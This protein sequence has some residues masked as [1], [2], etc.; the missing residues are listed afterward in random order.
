MSYLCGVIKINLIMSQT[1]A[2]VLRK[3]LAKPEEASRYYAVGRSGRVVTIKE[4]AKRIAER[5]SYSRGELEGCVGEYLL[6]IL[7]VLEEGNIAQMSDL[8]NFRMTVKTAIPT[9]TAAE[10]KAHCIEGGHVVFHPGKDLRKLCKNMEYTA[11]GKSAADSADGGGG[12]S[13]LPDDNT[14]SGGGGGGGE[15][16]D[17]AA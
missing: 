15:A 7:N 12:G 10:F 16:P 6:E 13:D 3:N 2:T 5:S 17:P 1:Y 4:I 11:A 14:P 9:L 8:G